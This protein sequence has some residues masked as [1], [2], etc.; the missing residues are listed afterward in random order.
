MT[1]KGCDVTVTTDTF[2]NKALISGIDVLRGT[3]LIKPEDFEFLTQHVGQYEKRFRTRAI[4]RSKTEM[5]AGVLNDNEH[6]TVDSKYWQA[7]GEQNVHLTELINL[8][9]ESKKIEADN[10]LLTAEI[11][12]LEE[13]L[14]SCMNS[15]EIKK[16]SAKIKRKRVELAQSQFGMTQQQ[17][18][19]QER[20][21]EVKHWDEIIE[22][23]EPNLEFGSEDFEI[24][25]PK[26]Y[27]LRYQ[28][29]MNNFDKLEPSAKESVLS[30]Y[31]SFTKMMNDGGSPLPIEM[32][33]K[34]PVIENKNIPPGLGESMDVNY[35]T[36]EEVYEKDPI[37]K[38]YFDHKV[39]KILVAAPHRNEKDGNVTN[40]FMM[41]TPAGF[42]CE[43]TEPFGYSVADAQNY[44]VKKA[45][46]GNF[47]YVFFVEDDNLI[48]R[49]ALVQLIHHN[50]DMVGGLY[51]R[52]YL[53]LETAGMHYDKDGCPSSIDNYEIGDIIDD[54]LVL[55]S[56]CT[57]I[58]VETL[59]KIEF[60]WY[61]SINVANR[62]A[63]TSDTYICQ[64]MREIGAK[65][66]T[67]TGVQCLHIDRTKG[68][69]YGHPDI[70]DFEKNE[71]KPEWREYFAV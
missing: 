10:D 27:F 23:L 55:C 51:Y 34:N 64:K 53:P 60:P 68:I 41:Q 12:E 67:D 50:T 19:A 1:K 15:I 16:L 8:S 48:P 30:H 13:Q 29:R 24:H 59:K 62:P 36:L 66:V 39:R 42:T 31:Q 52:K 57:L 49:N 43:I 63:L 38:K 40:F 3:E 61:K 5:I 46:D 33:M 35:S 65:I 4:Y 26:R 21:R 28:G 6:P 17:K 37:A 25:H 71:I 2:S 14:K 56:G 54:T 32:S 20:L 44:V 45:I 70:I 69:L 9:Y 7:I 58:K 11:E 22:Q 47:D 18:T